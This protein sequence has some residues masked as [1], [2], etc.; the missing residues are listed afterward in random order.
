M[1]G[2]HARKQLIAMLHAYPYASKFCM[3]VRTST[4]LQSL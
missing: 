1:R 3:T 4:I 2:V